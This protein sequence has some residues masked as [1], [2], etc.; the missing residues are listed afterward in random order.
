MSVCVSGEG[1]GDE[2]GKGREGQRERKE[3]RV[4]QD[5][6]ADLVTVLRDWAFHSGEFKGFDDFSPAPSFPL[7][8]GQ[9]DLSRL[10][11]SSK[12]PHTT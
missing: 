10:V 1:R 7:P 4:I 2:E 6:H 5:R 12:L 8:P 9:S 11:P 3:S